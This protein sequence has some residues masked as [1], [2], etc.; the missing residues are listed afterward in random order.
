[1]NARFASIWL[2][3]LIGLAGCCPKS[4]KP[5]GDNPELPESVQLPPENLPPRCVQNGRDLLVGKSGGNADAEVEA[6]LPFSTEVGKGV[7]FT[8]GFAVGALRQE[9]DGTFAVVARMNRDG[10][11]STVVPLARSHGDAEPPRVFS[12]PGV[13][14]AALLEPSGTKRSLRLARVDGESA[15]WGAELPQGNDE[16]LA[17]DVA[18]GAKRGVAV[19][20]DLPKDRDVSGIYV[21]TFDPTSLSNATMP[22]V[23][24]L[25]GVDADTPRLAKRDGGFWLFWTVR[26]PEGGEDYDARYR[27]ED[28]SNRWIEVVPIS[29]DGTLAG[30]PR[31]IGSESGHVLVY[32]VIEGKDGS[33]IVMWRDDDTP[34]GSVGGN[35]YAAVVRLGGVDGPDLIENESSGVGAPNLLPGWLAIS[36]AVSPTR[37]APM[38]GSGKLA[39]RLASEGLF[40]SGEP[41]AADAERLY[42][43]R[44]SGHGVRL[45]VASCG[46]D[47]RDA[48]VKPDASEDDLPSLPTQQ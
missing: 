14:G 2:P 24:T 41:L 1:M 4:P 38:D 35:L 7:A 12:S 16:S 9:G 37:L 32:D 15:Q 46:R 18:L 23:V 3:A 22:R 8:G 21:A 17:F 20:D 19:W 30:S 36:D 26:R 31:R 28:I 10:A 39:D 42:V 6:L 47:A 48:G 33:A 43:M 44:P 34:S 11:S 25:M 29:E 45:F 40:G 5:I 27:A 13:L